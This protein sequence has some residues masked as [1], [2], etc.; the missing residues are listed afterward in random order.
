MQIDWFTVI[1]Q[2]INFLILV[3]LLKRFLYKPV[4]KAIADREARIN[5]QLAEA[6]ASKAAAEGEYLLYKERNVEFDAEREKAL[7]KVA[8]DM[9]KE[10]QQL[11]LQAQKESQ[12]LRIKLQNDLKAEQHNILNE[13][14][15]R[16]QQTVLGIANKTLA[17]LGNTN[18]ETQIVSIFIQRL[19]HLNET[20][21]H[22]LIQAIQPGG[23]LVVETAYNLNEEQKKQLEN[24]IREMTG[25]HPVFQYEIDKSLIS[26][27]TL[28]MKDYKLSWNTTDYLNDLQKHMNFNDVADKY[29]GNEQ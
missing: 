10:K 21:A 6:A 14:K 16:I 12:T 19:K 17:D 20:E 29:W 13:V 15:Q 25:V 26:G 18:L 1:A 22:Q 3:C 11:L 5:K 8:I 9:E 27:I 7:E 23:N 24:T 4:L 2:V 28:K